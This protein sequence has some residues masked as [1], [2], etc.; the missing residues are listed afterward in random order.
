MKAEKEKIHAFF[1]ALT[2]VHVVCGKMT[3]HKAEKKAYK[4]LVDTYGEEYLE[5]LF[6]DEIKTEVK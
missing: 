3:R 4:H 6:K 5:E 2:A 1:T